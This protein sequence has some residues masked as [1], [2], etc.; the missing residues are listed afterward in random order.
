M[1][2]LVAGTSTA[3]SAGGTASANGDAPLLRCMNTIIHHRDNSEY[4]EQSDVFVMCVWWVHTSINWTASLRGKNISSLEC[5]GLY[6]PNLHLQFTVNSL[7]V[8]RAIHNLSGKRMGVRH[9]MQPVLS[10]DQWLEDTEHLPDQRGST[11][12]FRLF[13]NSA[14]VSPPVSF[15]LFSLHPESRQSK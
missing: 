3:P 6:S 15:T 13:M 12:S 1:V 5:S 4:S 8:S 2:S 14:E 9:M 7:S 10:A 11:A